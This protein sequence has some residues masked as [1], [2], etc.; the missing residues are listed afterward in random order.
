MKKVAMIS[1]FNKKPKLNNQASEELSWMLFGD[2]ENPIR[3]IQFFE[4]KSMDYSPGS[5]EMLDEY[6][7]GQR[8]NMPEGDELIKITLRSGSYV[9]EVI[10]RNAEEKYNWL[11]FSEAVKVSE[12]IEGIGFGLATVS[13]LWLEPD[14]FVFPMAKVLKRLENGADDSVSSLAKIVISGGL[15]DST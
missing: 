2:V 5:L 1:L 14:N 10:R 3:N 15:S 4:E 13:V 7:E 12:H 6:L 11:E 9:G 8:S